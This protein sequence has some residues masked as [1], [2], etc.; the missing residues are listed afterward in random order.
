MD[1]GNSPSEHEKLSSLPKSEADT[2]KSSRE[3][4]EEV[5]PAEQDLLE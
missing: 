4:E 3:P 1:I 5:D 2:E